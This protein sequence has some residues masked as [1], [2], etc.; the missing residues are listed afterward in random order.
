MTLHLPESR[1]QHWRDALPGLLAN[2]T[3]SPVEVDCGSWELNCTDLIDL[4][5]RLLDIGKPLGQLLCRHPQ[6]V[7]AARALGMAVH[8][9]APARDPRP[10]TPQK[11]SRL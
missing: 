11:P 9:S 5:Q 1:H 10:G 7:V 8:Q 3:D 6:T 4:E 2:C